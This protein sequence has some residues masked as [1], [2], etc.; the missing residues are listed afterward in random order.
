MLNLFCRAFSQCQRHQVHPNRPLQVPAQL[1]KVLRRLRPKPLKLDLGLTHRVRR[2]AK[3]S[4][5]LRRTDSETVNAD[6]LT[7]QNPE[8]AF[9][10]AALVWQLEP[11]AQ[12]W[13]VVNSEDF[14]VGL[15]CF[16]VT[17]N[18]NST[19]FAHIKNVNAKSGTGNL[20]L[21]W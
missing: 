13:P 3:W 9:A 11:S 17:L 2:T 19:F 5:R 14:K 8:K 10:V 15:K 16:N 4:E 1:T 6:R 7:M 12:N 20:K 21:F 18:A